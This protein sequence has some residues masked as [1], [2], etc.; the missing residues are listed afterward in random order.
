MQFG[1]E[2]KMLYF[3]SNQNEKLLTFSLSIFEDDILPKVDLL[4]LF[5]P[6]TTVNGKVSTTKLEGK[7]DVISL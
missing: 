1:Y 7:M 4:V 5:W 2:S 6:L 3:Y